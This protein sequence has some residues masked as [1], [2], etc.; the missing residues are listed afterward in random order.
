MSPF[1]VFFFLCTMI[2]SE[3]QKKNCPSII[4]NTETIY[5]GSDNLLMS[6]M[7]HYIRIGME[8]YLYRKFI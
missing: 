8:M 2:L 5:E 4:S 6:L 1:L 7:L 3:L